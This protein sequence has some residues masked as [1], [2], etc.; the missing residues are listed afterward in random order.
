MAKKEQP[1]PPKKPEVLEAEVAVLLLEE[2]LSDEELRQK[3]EALASEPAFNGLTYLWGPELYSRNRVM[4]RP[5]ILN[6]FGQMFQLGWSWNP[7]R[8]A[9]HSSELNAWLEE[10][11]RRNDAELFQRLYAWRHAQSEWGG[12][13]SGQWA[14]DLLA[15]FQA[16][17]ERHE[18]NQVLSKFDI[19]GSVLDEKT[20][21]S[22]YQLDP[23]A[24]RS[25]IL[26]HP[27]GGGRW[28]DRRELPAKLCSA[29]QSAA[30]TDCISPCTGGWS[31]KR[32]GKK[33]SNRW[34]K[35]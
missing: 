21:V 30:T 17:K 13:D 6:H 16:A 11:D 31:R 35:R 18:R 28:G 10:V 33:T 32:R 7:V 12:L 27:T 34:R 3:L 4:F 2:K 9:D 19:R 26:K 23:E 14:K 22:L 8:W 1:P 15:R 25:F 29:A 20:A 24:A 5:F